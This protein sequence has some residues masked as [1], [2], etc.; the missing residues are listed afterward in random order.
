MTTATTP[1]YSG[2]SFGQAVSSVFSKYATFSGRATRSEYWFWALFEVIVGLVFTFAFIGTFSWAFGKAL[3]D[4][5]TTE[6]NPVGV[7]FFVIVSV[8]AGVWALATLIP[9]LSVTVRRF[10]DAG[11]T[12]WLWFLNLI[13]SI[14]SIVVFVF[15]LLP[16]SPNANEWGMAPTK[17]S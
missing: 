15:M 9:N 5:A 2:L 17:R 10:H 11:Y 1:T 14:G 3:F 8:L 12:G 16:S 13:P 7:T 6:A 4:E